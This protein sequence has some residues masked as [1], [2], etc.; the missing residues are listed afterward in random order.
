MELDSAISSFGA[1]SANSSFAVDSAENGVD[2]AESVV[3]SADFGV[4]SAENGVDS[5][6][7]GVDSAEKILHEVRKVFAS[8]GFCQTKNPPLTQPTLTYQARR[9]RRI[10]FCDFKFWSRFCGKFIKI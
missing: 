1:D 8:F 6:E 3:D 10:R 9:I 7:N 2:S 4:D 5:A